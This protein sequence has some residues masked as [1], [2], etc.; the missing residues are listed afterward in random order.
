MDYDPFRG[1]ERSAV[2]REELLTLAQQ[3]GFRGVRLWPN[4]TIFVMERFAAMIASHERARLA[5]MQG[6]AHGN[7]TS[8]PD[9]CI[10]DINRR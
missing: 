7:D 10:P 5:S 8:P 9:L 2:S 4:R 6:V 3:A 1:E